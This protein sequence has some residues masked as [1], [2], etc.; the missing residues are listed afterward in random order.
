MNPQSP[1]HVV[2][3]Q[4]PKNAGVAAVLGLFLGPVGLLYA[5]RLLP[6]VIMFFVGGIAE[7]VT[8]G[9]GL[10]IIGPICAVWAYSAANAYNK[11][12]LA[13]SS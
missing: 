13:G 2:V 7:L 8:F 12:L 5:G 9:F 1:K 11:K 4:I 6:A 3:L 10:I